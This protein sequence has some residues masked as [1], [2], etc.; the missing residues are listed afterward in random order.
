MKKNILFLILFAPLFIKGQ[1]LEFEKAFYTIAPYYGSGIKLSNGGYTLAGGNFN[2]AFLLRLNSAGDT[3]LSKVYHFNYPSPGTGHISSIE[4]SL[5]NGNFLFGTTSFNNT[6]SYFIA[7]S[8]SLGNIVWVRRYYDYSKTSLSGKLKTSDG[9]F[10]IGGESFDGVLSR[11]FI[12]KHNSLGNPLWGKI[13]NEDSLYIIG[14][15]EI[16]NTY[17]ILTEKHSTWEHR[18]LK[19]DANGNFLDAIKI[20]SS[21]YFLGSQSYGDGLLKKTLDNNLI[22]FSD[23]EDTASHRR[24]II[25]KI[26]TAGN[27]IFAR[28]YT[29]TGLSYPSRIIQTADSGY[30]FLSTSIC[31][32]SVY[33]FLLIRIDKNGGTLWMKSYSQGSYENWCSDM[34]ETTDKGFIITGFNSDGELYLIKTDS[35]G[36]SGCEHSC[37]YLVSSPH[38]LNTSH[39]NMNLFDITINESNLSI[40]EYSGCDVQTYCTNVGI[41]EVKA[42]NAFSVYPNPISSYENTIN[43]SFEK[44]SKN[45]VMEIFNMMGEKIYT[46][47]FSGNQ[48]A[49]N[50]SLIGGTSFV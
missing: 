37:N 25:T 23:L 40:S 15:E 43:I 48:K 21:T 27:V 22:L 29:V 11:Y 41:G 35:L 49:I 12:S 6:D 26:D 44:N 33:N 9:G 3:L 39:I 8:D 17:F 31:G 38:V 16:D 7:Q 30:A 19:L 50:C 18:I 1:V 5:N 42:E 20:N 47:T 4:P 13:I 14:M 34:E 24:M 36:E 10:L 45:G 46:E 2:D 28:T 32:P